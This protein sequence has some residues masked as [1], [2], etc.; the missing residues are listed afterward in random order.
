MTCQAPIQQ[1]ARKGELCGR[2]TEEQYCSKH[3]RQAIIDK[4]IKENIRYCDI[5]RG[6]Y[7]VLADY[8]AKCMHCLHKARIN[9]RK[10][11]D[12]KRQDPNLCLDCGR[13]LTDAIRAKGKH[14]KP[15]R[16]CVPCYEKLLKQES[17][18]PE[19]NRNFKAEAFTNKH[20]IWNHYV[21]GAKKRGIPFALSR[22]HFQEL[23]VKPCFYCKYHKE[24]EV[25]GIDRV[26]NQKGY[27]ENNVVPCC[28]TCNVLK[29]SQ[30]PQ[31]F[32]DKMWAIHQY[33]TLKQPITSELV[34]KWSTYRSK[35]TPHYKTYAKSATSRNI[36]FQLSEPEF[37]EM[38][39]QSCYLCGLVDKNGIDR[40]DNVKGYLLE[41]CRACCGHCNLMKKD[42]TYESILRNAEQI[43][44][45]YAELTEWIGTKSIRIRVSK[46]EPRI[47]IENPDGKESIQREYKPLNEII[48]PQQTPNDIQQLEKKAEVILPKQ[49]K[50]KQIYEFIQENRENEY[51]TYCE[52]NNTVQPTW[53][54]IWITFVLS[55]KG[56]SYTETKPIIRSFVENLRRIRHNQLCAKDIVEKEEREVWPAITVVRAFLEGKID[57]FKI[58]NETH[59]NESPAD[60][61]WIKR[62]DTFIASLKQHRSDE[63]VLK[64][65]CSK[66]MTA[67]RTKK[68]RTSKNMVHNGT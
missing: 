58:H 56:K 29:G 5:A 39:Q 66:F 35:T 2:E 16:R 10:A 60:P 57:K 62:W 55:V 59:H 48:L 47:K 50:T 9:D 26:D 54:E 7:T 33:I 41:N 51:K 8:E 11:N 46:T 24:G 30:H 37:S 42:K 20:V 63:S 40:F 1:G 17:E 23:I 19:R 64:G 49:W 31:E 4:A 44:V 65:V 13:T 67:Q 3:K 32:I 43:Y 15:L 34:E 45:T 36:I 68:Y 21:K 27:I 18:R 14:D 53:N 25:N 6:C 52:Q 12:K 38:V 22:T 28:E 61:K